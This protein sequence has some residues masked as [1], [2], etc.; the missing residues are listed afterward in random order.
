MSQSDHL[1]LTLETVGVKEENPLVDIVYLHMHTTACVDLHL[2]VYTTT[3]RKVLGSTLVEKP[4]FLC[5][6]AFP[7]FLED[8]VWSPC[9]RQH[10][11]QALHYHTASY[12][13]WVAQLF[14]LSCVC[15]VL[16]GDT[17]DGEPQSTQEVVLLSAAPPPCA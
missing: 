17:V 3:N 4:L 8:L 16:L 9:P 6:A 1:C 13:I 12:G 7:H 15:H 14:Y 11:T 10:A 2:H 5:F